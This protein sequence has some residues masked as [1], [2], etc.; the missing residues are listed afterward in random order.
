MKKII[1]FGNSGS[2]KSTLATHYAAKFQLQ[3]LDLDILAWEDTV[4][5]TRK[6]LDISSMKINQFIDNHPYWVIEGCY[7]DLITIAVKNA[8]ELIFLNPGVDTCISNCHKRSWE[9]HKYESAEKQN[10]NLNM[11]L[12]WVKKYPIRTDESS[13]ESHTALFNAFDGTKIEYTSNE[14]KLDIP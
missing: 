5:P 9:P 2:G 10:E 4:P 8:D 7:A 6:P 1:V 14:R 11:L 13:L 12:D 3:H